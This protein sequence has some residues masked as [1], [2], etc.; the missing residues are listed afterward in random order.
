MTETPS[1]AKESPGGKDRPR[2]IFARMWRF[3]RE[4]IAELKKV[5][6]PTRKELV[7]MTIVVVV[8]V[9]IMM[10]IVTGLDFLFGGIAGW[11][12]AGKF[13]WSM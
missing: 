4:V 1:K 6:R 13:N 7:N 8:F 2:N 3:L 12:F 5:V 11:V 10:A 9:V